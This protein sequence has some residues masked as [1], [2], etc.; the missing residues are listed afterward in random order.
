ML[1]IN[2]PK[3][4]FYFNCIIIIIIIIIIISIISFSIV[5]ITIIIIIIIID[6]TSFSIIIIILL[7][8]IIFVRTSFLVF[9]KVFFC[10]L[11]PR[12]IDPGGCTYYFL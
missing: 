4:P 3:T 5:I 10:R 2:Q 12:E 1:K 8:I 9:W 11:G 6:I 7:I